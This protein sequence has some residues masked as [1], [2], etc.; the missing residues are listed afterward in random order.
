M[1]G[2]T[3]GYEPPALP[4]YIARYYDYV[5]GET[6][7]YEPTPWGDFNTINIDTLWAAIQQD[8]DEE[9]RGVAEMW[10]RIAALLE[11]TRS[12]IE[13]YATALQG[14]WSGAASEA[15]LRRVG[16]ALYSLDEWQRAASTNE[17]TL[18]AVADK[19]A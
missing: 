13:R 4:S 15:F 8:S 17:S 2:N 9:T 12:N 6:T 11:T 1:P 18:N 16:A 3:F 14:A 19:I 10:R 7:E 5:G